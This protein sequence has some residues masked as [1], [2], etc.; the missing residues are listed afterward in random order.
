MRSLPTSLKPG[1]HTGPH[2]APTGFFSFKSGSL[3]VA[4]T[5]LDL[6]FLCPELTGVEHH[7]WLPALGHVIDAHFEITGE[8]FSWTT[9]FRGL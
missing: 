1:L 3:Y 9:Q 2:P 7:A 8:D 5:G 6:S 4:H